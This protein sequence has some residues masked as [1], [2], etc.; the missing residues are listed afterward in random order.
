[1]SRKGIPSRKR[2]PEKIETKEKSKTGNMKIAALFAAAMIIVVGAFV[3]YSSQPSA[4]SKVGVI[5]IGGEI[6]GFDYAKLAEKARTDPSIEAVVLRINSPGGSV[7]GTFQTE[8]SISKLENKKPVVTSL[9]EYATSGAYVIASAS[10][11]VYA[12]E[13]T[14]T[15]GLG[16]I[17]TWIS[18]EDYYD[19]QGIDYFVWKTGEE[20]D[21]FAPYRKPTAEENQIIQNIV[22][23][24][25]QELFQI[26]TKNR[27]RTENYI[28]LVKDGSTI[29]GK[30]AIQ[31]K[32]IDN[33]GGYKEAVS[34]AAEL[35]NLEMGKVVTVNLRDYYS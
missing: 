19:D 23:S 18:Y 21:M 10:D 3:F 6:N 1:M 5:N 17:A 32:L 9:Q 22:E 15:A 25:E 8:T 13:Q 24:Y 20:K 11:E 29:T 34:K 14:T 26:V 35:A 27:P 31:Y 28:D 4:P 16:V 33:I 2:E 30:K 12:Y 7:K